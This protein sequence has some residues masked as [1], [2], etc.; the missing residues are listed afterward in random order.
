MD[1]YDPINVAPGTFSFITVVLPASLRE[2]TAQTKGS[3][4]EV[5]RL[6][7]LEENLDH[8]ELEHSK[9]S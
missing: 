3:D 9:D 8:Y 7:E 2:F 4:I 5:S 6:V 1:Y